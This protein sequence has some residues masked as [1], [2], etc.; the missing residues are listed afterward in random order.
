MNANF[1]YIMSAVIGAGLIILVFSG[2][3]WL[4]GRVPEFPRAERLSRLAQ[5]EGGRVHG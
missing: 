2:L 4:F 1:G 5:H 3:S